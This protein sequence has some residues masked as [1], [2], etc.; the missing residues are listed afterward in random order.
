ML[1]LNHR[2]AVVAASTAM[3]ISLMAP[4]AFAEDS[5]PTSTT[6]GN[7]PATA[8][9]AS[10]DSGSTSSSSSS[11]GDKTSS[12]QDASVLWDGEKT[13][14]YSDDKAQNVVVKVNGHEITAEKDA[15]FSFDCGIYYNRDFYTQIYL[16]AGMSFK[17][18]TNISGDSK[19]VDQEGN[20]YEDFY[21]TYNV[22]DADG[23]EQ[24]VR[25]HYRIIFPV[26]AIVIPGAEWAA[27]VFEYDLGTLAADPEITVP[28]NAVVEKQ[29]DPESGQVTMTIKITASDADE[30]YTYTVKW[31][32]AANE[33]AADAAQDTAAAKDNTAAA[34]KDNSAAQ[35]QSTSV[36]KLSRTQDASGAAVVSL[37]AAAIGA[38]AL[39]RRR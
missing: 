25:L 28:E 21:P 33:P 34:A 39:A 5:D 14:I 11:A 1:K 15:P 32:V 23:Q 4:A 12:S 35:T 29:V 24:A 17:T 36:S 18:D 13:V 22:E 20:G 19:T 6:T 27:D 37:I 8:Q 26:P 7:D 3:V 10:S 2:S 16:P 9:S 38:A 31:T 30:G